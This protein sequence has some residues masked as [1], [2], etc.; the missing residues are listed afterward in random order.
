M[1]RAGKIA[2]HLLLALAAWIGGESLAN[3]AL[4]PN[5]FQLAAI[6]TAGALVAELFLQVERAPWRF[7]SVSDLLRLA[8]SA[9][10]TGAL[11]V[12]ATLVLH[13]KIHSAPRAILLATM[14]YFVLLSGLRISR[15]AMSEGSLSRS[16][17]RL[18]PGADGAAKTRGRLLIVGSAGEADAFLR[19]P[20]NGL[21]QRYAT[22]G[23][24]SPH[25]REIGEEL[26][27][28]CVLGGVD[29]FDD[30]MA[31]LRE[32]GLPPAAV[33]FLTQPAAISGLNAERLGRLKGEGV[34]LLRLP[35]V[36]ELSYGASAGDLR[37]ISLQELLTRPPVRLEFEP[38]RILVA[39]RRV[40]ITGAG[41]SIGSEVSRQ[42]AACGCSH[43]TLLDSSEAALFRISR[44]IEESWPSTSRADVLCDI[45]DEARLREVFEAEKPDLVFHVAA[46]KHVPLVEAHPCEGVRTNVFGALNVAE[47]ART[48]GAT[49]M[50]FISTDKAVNPSSVMGATKRLAE[51]LIRQA[52]VKSG[53]TRFSIVR[54]GNVLGSAGSVATVFQQQI[55]RG[56]PV[57]VTDEA[58]E[59]YFMTIPEA[60]QL[61]LRA[62]AMSAARSEP[63]P[64]VL[65]LEMGE[66]VKIIDLA[67]RMIEL[68]GLTPDTD[69]E[70][71]IIGLRPGEKITEELVDVNE[72]Q[73]MRAPGVIEAAPR[74]PPPAITPEDLAQLR[75]LAM[76]GDQM[77]VRHTLF[78][79][80]DR[81]RTGV[82]EPAADNVTLLRR[83]RQP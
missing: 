67:R 7:L 4:S 80:I 41:G 14:L 23:I 60:V 64:G 11:F 28:A 16:L 69:V 17:L 79:F 63:E 77:A 55:E 37:E 78:G 21:L 1:G 20:P 59:R 30:V 51:A 45:R 48:I 9:A 46:L 10:V 39:G 58:M 18:R 50:A 75:A 81:I 61:V 19:S 32:S 12:V 68:Q 62:V 76:D 8:R 13:L 44:E 72:E 82:E 38:G 24:I 26:R 83:P 35:A 53:N 15:R 74:V 34:R 42:I 65:T 73:R 43:L 47:A 56:G 49:H 3:G 36:I 29:Q 25:R 66:P 31:R 54:F 27:G 22:I 5:T 57:T 33:L 6:F 52:G 70:I 71:R 40:L 2:V